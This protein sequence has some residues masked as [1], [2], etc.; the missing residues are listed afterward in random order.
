MNMN[1]A[2][3]S[4][5]ASIDFRKHE[6]FEKTEANTFYNKNGKFYVI[7]ISEFINYNPKE[8]S[9]SE[10]VDTNKQHYYEVRTFD[11]VLLFR[12]V[13][14]TYA[15]ADII[16]SSVGYPAW[17]SPQ[18]HNIHEDTI[19]RK[20]IDNIKIKRSDEKDFLKNLK[21]IQNIVD[22]MYGEKE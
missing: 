20:I 14:N 9:S 5:S 18:S 22:I 17:D 13:I 6:S 3:D 4:G 1:N 21:K 19:Y 7:K 8:Q 2:L 16:F 12:G 15:Q 11:D 10:Y